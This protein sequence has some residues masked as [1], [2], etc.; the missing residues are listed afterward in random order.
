MDQCHWKGHCEKFRQVKSSTA[1]SKSIFQ[2]YVHSACWNQ[3]SKTTHLEANKGSGVRGI[4]FDVTAE[5][6]TG[7]LVEGIQLKLSNVMS[8]LTDESNTL[9]LEFH[10]VKHH[11]QHVAR[12]GSFP[13]RP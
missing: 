1:Q 5:V 8:S 13:S 12:N 4:G 6:L 3:S 9:L 2:F 11:D 7:D 10:C